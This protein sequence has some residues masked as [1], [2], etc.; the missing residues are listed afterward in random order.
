[1]IK[2]CKLLLLLLI[3]DVAEAALTKHK[4][5]VLSQFGDV[6]N[7]VGGRIS[8]NIQQQQIWSN[9]CYI[10][11]SASLTN[12]TKPV[13]EANY[14]Q[15]NYLISTVIKYYITNAHQIAAKSVDD[16]VNI[17]IYLH[18]DSNAP[19]HIAQIH[20][21]LANYYPMLK[22]NNIN[23]INITKKFK[24]DK[25]NFE[26]RYGYLPHSL[27]NYEPAD[28]ILSISPVV[29]VNDQFN[30]KHVMVPIKIIPMNLDSMTIVLQQQYAV[31]NHLTT[32]IAELVGSQDAARINDFNSQ[33]L[34]NTP[35]NLFTADQFDLVNLIQVDGYFK[36]ALLPN[37][38][39]VR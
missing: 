12:L 20:Y 24:F 2:Y 9:L 29:S 17:I 38:F 8:Q 7:I 10:D 31:K 13:Q 5:E 18:R 6:I 35:I 36:P 32:V 1:M 4:I 27:V 23:T 37:F 15:L 19:K 26:Y 28:I 25:V 11:D 22:Q 21:S 14:Q 34:T 39:Y 3:I 16:E 33:H 30:V